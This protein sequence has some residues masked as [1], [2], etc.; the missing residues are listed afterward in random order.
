MERHV[1]FR[2]KFN[3]PF[4]LIADPGHKIIDRYGVWGEKVLYGRHYMGLHRTTFVIDEDGYISRVY[5]RPRNKVH[6]EE[7]LKHAEEAVK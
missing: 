2:E 7:I 5:L 1:R 4:P 6:A 3:L